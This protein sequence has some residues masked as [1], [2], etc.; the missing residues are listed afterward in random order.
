MSISEENKLYFEDV[1]RRRFSTRRFK[2]DEVPMEDILK[3]LEMGRIA[4]TAKNFQPK[5]IYVATKA[6]DLEK[7]D[8]VTRC[9][10]NAPLVFI[11]CSDRGEAWVED[12]K[13]SYEMDATIVATHMM[14]EATN[15][16]I[17]SI[18]I[19]LFDKDELK[20]LF[21]LSD[22][23]EPIALLPMGYGTDDNRP[24]HLH[25]KRKPLEETV[26]FL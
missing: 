26:T 11:I 13:T 17:D 6:S 8:Q 3:I 1:L 4:P 23:I 20:R 16:G 7:L 14:L 24:S 22:N 2:S 18:W 12:K 21:N 10:Y 19:E 5:R 15:I 25:D 9:R